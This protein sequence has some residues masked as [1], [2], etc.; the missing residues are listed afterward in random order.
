MVTFS[1][2]TRPDESR[3]RVHVKSRRAHW[4]FGH[5]QTHTLKGKTRNLAPGEPSLVA[6]RGHAESQR[7]SLD[8]RVAERQ[9][10]LKVMNARA[11]L[12]PAYRLRVFPTDELR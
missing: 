9:G 10:T 8:R 5:Q 2:S 3:G 4:P 7:A 12:A 1:F 6:K 11:T